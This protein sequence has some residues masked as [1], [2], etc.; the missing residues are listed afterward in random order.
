[1]I[2]VNKIRE[3]YPNGLTF[4]EYDLGDFEK[5]EWHDDLCRLVNLIKNDTDGGWK[6]IFHD[7]LSVCK[8]A[9]F[10]KVLHSF[11]DFKEEYS[12]SAI[13]RYFPQVNALLEF[14][15]GQDWRYSN[16]LRT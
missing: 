11:E 9:L 8:N 2:K 14:Y 6:G 10:L 13:I 15:C 3:V 7:Y 4:V 1:M 12:N 5:Q 16:Q